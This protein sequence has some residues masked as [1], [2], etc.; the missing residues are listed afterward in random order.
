L[1]VIYAKHR[2]IDAGIAGPG[3]RHGRFR[4]Q[5]TPRKISKRKCIGESGSCRRSAGREERGRRTKRLRIE[6]GTRLTESIGGRTVASP[7]GRT[8]EAT[9]RT[10]GCLAWDGLLI[11]LIVGACAVALSL[12]SH[13]RKTV[14]QE[15]A[16]WGN[17]TSANH[18]IAGSQRPLDLRYDVHLAKAKRGQVRDV[19]QLSVVAFLFGDGSMEE[20]SNTGEEDTRAREPGNSLKLRI[21]LR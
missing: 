2:G 8:S 7:G 4:K 20:E 9:R 18:A 10:R 14:N 11:S 13:Q 17:L 12:S 16:K 5:R 19:P 6:Q 3:H 21:T 15:W 1:D